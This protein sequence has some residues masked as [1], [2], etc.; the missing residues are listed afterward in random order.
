M[1]EGT[2]FFRIA[3]GETD[4]PLVYEDAHVVAFRDLHPIAPVHLLIVPKRAIASLAETTE[5]DTALLGHLLSV[6]R[7]LAE[8]QGIAE[9]GYKLVLNTG[10]DAGQ[11]VPHLHLH[12]IGGKRVS[13]AT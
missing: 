10:P 5:D 3:N 13:D 2:I 7:R 1:T 8:D 11:S 12:L 4:T 6:A 9:S